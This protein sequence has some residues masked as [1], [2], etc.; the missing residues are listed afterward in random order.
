MGV[1][2]N[3]TFDKQVSPYGT[4]TDDH[5][6]LGNGLKQLDKALTRAGLP[7][8]GQFVSADPSEWEDM[9]PDDPHATALPPLQWFDP[10]DGLL[11]VRS[12]MA[13][14]RAKPRAVSWSADALD[15]LEQVEA[16]LAAAQ[17]RKA[18]FHF[19]ICD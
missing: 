16:E 9:D 1:S 7:T 8:L 19:A 5:N 18:R 4:L 13:H 12:A 10:A 14:L 11:A 17:K 6:A 15:E 2:L 3:V